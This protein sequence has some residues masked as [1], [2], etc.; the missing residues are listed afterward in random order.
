VTKFN[1]AEKCKDCGARHALFNE[2][3]IYFVPEKFYKMAAEMGEWFAE[4]NIKNW[5]LGPIQSRRSD[6]DEGAEPEATVTHE[7]NSR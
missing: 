2:D 1:D 4:R 3:A 6:D 7:D 5:E